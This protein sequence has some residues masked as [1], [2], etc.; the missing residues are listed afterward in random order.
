MALFHGC[1]PLFPAMALCLLVGQP[2]VACIADRMRKRG[3]VW[4]TDVNGCM[5]VAGLLV[6]A[7]LVWKHHALGPNY[8]EVLGVD[9]LTDGYSIVQAYKML[10][11]EA[12]QAG[13]ERRVDMLRTAFHVVA[14]KN[15]A[16]F[17]Y[18]Q[19]GPDALEL[20]GAADTAHFLP[21]TYV[22]GCFAAMNAVLTH[23]EQARG[24]SSWLTS[25]LVLLLAADASIR[26]L[27]WSPRYKLVGWVTPHEMIVYARFIYP[28]V[29]L[30]LCLWKRVRAVDSHQQHRHELE[31]MRRQATS[32]ASQLTALRRQ[33]LGDG[34][35]SGDKAGAA[36]ATPAPAQA[37]EA[38]DDVAPGSGATDGAQLRQRRRR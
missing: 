23:A 29:A 33:L 32:I 15:N 8:F 10:A 22:Y 26:F 7:Q 12:R 4:G 13:D 6:F 28:S 2:L 35:G 1:E 34:G 3:R 25:V 16:R 37:V 19:F 5:V 36:S 27:A 38:G 20:E 14:D 24:A 21:I 11:T 9:R 31:L 17:V 18:E 30:A